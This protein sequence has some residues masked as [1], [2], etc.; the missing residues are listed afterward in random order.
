MLVLL[1]LMLAC[2]STKAEKV[3][4]SQDEYVIELC[5]G[6]TPIDPNSPRA[7]GLIP[8]SCYYSE[9]TG[10]LCF[11]FDH[12]LGDVTIT[13]TEVYLGV[14]SMDDYSTSS[15]FVSIP[16]SGP[17]TFDISILIAMGTEYTGQFAL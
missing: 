16:V 1:G 4:P 13:V 8:I 10:N 6:N 11:I 5:A 2:F 9:A 14:V 12:S 3:V 7:P 17:G 15:L